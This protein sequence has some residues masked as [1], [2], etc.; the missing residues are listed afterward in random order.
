MK[1]DSNVIK[2][3]IISSLVGLPFTVLGGVL[4]A[5]IVSK[6]DITI[7][8]TNAIEKQSYI[9]ET[10]TS[11][12]GKKEFELVKSY[13]ELDEENGRVITYYVYDIPIENYIE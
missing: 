13:T 5:M 4:V 11:P 10:F 3:T 1:K 9:R 6:S 7:P 8:T 12:Q 2:D